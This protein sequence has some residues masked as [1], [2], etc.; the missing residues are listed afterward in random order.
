MK[1]VIAG[2]VVGGLIALLTLWGA[3]Q[4]KKLSQVPQYSH[5]TEPFR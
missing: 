4:D 2:L 5:S 1:E 3:E